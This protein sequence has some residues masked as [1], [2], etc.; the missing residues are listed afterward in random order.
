MVNENNLKLM[1]NKK[2]TEMVYEL[3]DEIPRYYCD[4]LFLCFFV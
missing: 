1:E 3:K 2:P 4:W